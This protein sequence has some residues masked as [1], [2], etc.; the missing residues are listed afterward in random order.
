MLKIKKSYRLLLSALL[1][2]GILLLQFHFHE[3]EDANESCPVCIVQ[4]V[5]DISDAP[6]PL[7][8]LTFVPFIY[9]VVAAQ[10]KAIPLR[11]SRSQLSRAPP[12]LS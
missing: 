4:E 3:H 10:T 2:S 9:I 12:K 1:F 6:S 8:A 7:Y 5:F 11:T